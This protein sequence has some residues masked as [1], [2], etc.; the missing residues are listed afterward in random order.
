MGSLR[1]F[2]MAVIMSLPCLASAEVVAYEFTGTIFEI[3]G[4]S[5]GLVSLG[6]PVTGRFQYST[7]LMTQQWADE[8]MVDLVVSFAGMVF[9]SDS[10]DRMGAST[11][12]WFTDSTFYFGAGFDGRETGIGKGSAYI[13]LISPIDTWPSGSNPVTLDLNTMR[14]ARV[15]F[16]YA[17]YYVRANLTNLT[18]VEPI[19]VPEPSAVALSFF[20]IGVFAIGMILR[21]RRTI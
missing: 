12:N 13:W 7:D 5:K 19:S 2:L 11:S 8:G 16:S 9:D 3:D 20:A 6:D 21:A 17:G 15:E 18:R 4:K 14:L 1:L 10:N